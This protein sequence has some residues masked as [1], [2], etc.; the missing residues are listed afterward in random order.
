MAVNRSVQSYASIQA[1]NT[2]QSISTYAN[3]ML[4][5]INETS[6]TSFSSFGLT[7]LPAPKGAILVLVNVNQFV[8]IGGALSPQSVLFWFR[9]S[10]FSCRVSLMSVFPS[11]K[12]QV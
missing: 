1:S 9:L 12:S 11:L 10:S 3:V 5:F 7:A 2:K 4:R 8:C 6:L